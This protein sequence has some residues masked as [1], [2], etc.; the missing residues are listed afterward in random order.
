MEM[1]PPGTLEA[2]GLYVA[3]TSAL[4]AAAPLLGT[5]T[6]F[7]TWRIGLIVAVSF[8]LYSVSGAP[9]PTSPAPIEYGALVLRELLI[10]L[11]LAFVLQAVVV[12][13][14][15]AGESI[16][17]EMG[18]NMASQ[19]DPVSNVQTP[20]ITQFYETFFF[21][22]L[23]AVNG[24]H[25]LLRALER[26]FERAPIGQISFSADASWLAL[27]LFQQMF[28]AGLTIA[29]PVLVLL[30]LTSILIGLLTRMVPTINVMDIGFTA[31]IAVG[32]VAL[33]VFSPFLAP[34]FESLY[35]ALMNGLDRALDVLAV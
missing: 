28:V 10:G 33:L 9:L 6:G 19:L 23:L 15:V 4:V 18:F 16:G 2:L 27:T 31:R 21:L 11:F 1:I 30:V 35:T 13:V 20:V 29:A 7:V 3:R 34:A 26:S 5:G 22:G 32:F 17:Q 24:H 25:L 8:L 12:A 14:R